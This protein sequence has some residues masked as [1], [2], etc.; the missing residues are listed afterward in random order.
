MPLAA[1]IASTV[2]EYWREIPQ[3]VSPELTTWVVCTEAVLTAVADV[4]T[5]AALEGTD[6]TTVSVAE[7][8]LVPMC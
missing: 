1:A 7:R 5:V 6:F 2:V 8:L 3:R 4:T